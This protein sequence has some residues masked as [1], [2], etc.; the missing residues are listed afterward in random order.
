MLA[1]AIRAV[2]VQH[3]RRCGAGKRAIVAH[4]TPQATGFGAAAARIQDRHR[5]VVGED[6]VCGHHMR[7]HCVHQGTQQVRALANPI[8]QG[9]TVQVDAGAGVDFG[10]TIRCCTADYVAETLAVP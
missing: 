10:L 4:I 7:T 6:A 3:R 9:G 1:F 8:G 2:A 5:G